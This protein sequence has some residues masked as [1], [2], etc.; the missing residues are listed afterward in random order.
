MT[1]TRKALTIAAIA[2]ALGAG[3]QWIT[4]HLF[5][6]ARVPSTSPDAVRT[7]LVWSTSLPDLAGREQALAQ[8]QGKVTVMN[9]WATWC[10]HCRR[11]T[12][13]LI[14]L[15]ERF[16]AQGVQVVGVA[17][18]DGEQVGAYVRATGINYPILVGG[19]RAA[20]LGQ[21]A[22]NPLGGIPYTVVFD[23]Q[24]RAVAAVTGALSEARLEAMITPLL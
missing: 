20:A 11:E 10:P 14:S 9:F 6:S 15:Q 13:G 23:R 22:G 3:Y 5:A 21:A 17:L 16:G 24:G 4:S 12:P 2:I 18:D 8:W 19:W 7:D 1:G